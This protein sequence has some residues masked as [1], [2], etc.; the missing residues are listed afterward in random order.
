[1]KKTTKRIIAAMT[2]AATLTLVT[3]IAAVQAAEILP[4]TVP[5][6]ATAPELDHGY[7]V[8]TMTVG[9][10]GDVITSEDGGT[11]L[12]KSDAYILA[13]DGSALDYEDIKAGDVIT[14]LV[15]PRV[16][17]TLQ[18]PV[19]YSPAV[20]VVG[21]DKAEVTCK[22]AVFDEDGLSDDGEL[23]LNYDLTTPYYSRTREATLIS[24]KALVLYNMMTMSIPAQ[25][26]P[27][28]IVKL[29]DDEKLVVVPG[30]VAAPTEDHGYMAGTMT[31][32][33]NGETIANEDGS[34]H[35]NKPEEVVILT[36]DGKPANYE[37]IKT[38]DVIT[39]YVDGNAPMTLQLPVHYTPAVIVVGADEAEVTCKIAVFDEE[40]LSDDGELVINYDLTTPYY[41]R[42]REATFIS[43]KAL[44]L[45]N[46]MTMSIPAQ[47]NPLAIV[48][49]IDDEPEA[50][51][52]APDL[53]GVKNIVIGENTIAHLPVTVNG[54]QMLPVRAVAEALGYQVDWT[55]ET[56]SV[57]VGFASFSIDEDSYAFARRAP[58]SLG[59]APV[60]IALPTEK[61]ARTYVPVTFFTEVLEH[62]MTV[63]GDT[64][65]I[66]GN[67]EPMFIP[68]IAPG[69]V[70]VPVDVPTTLPLLPG[71]FEV[72][73]N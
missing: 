44:V 56:L 19:T 38:G 60:L 43:G 13:A 55:G 42:T 28:A 50:A 51:P 72:P 66:S 65:Y 24:G 71:E 57:N 31:V 20:I 58:Q 61:Y 46:M 49:L 25:T 67:D 37:D 27:L 69:E 11:C 9:E 10:N 30:P 7:L 54:V 22:I 35:L 15:D 68:P 36:A 41:S 39:Y 2:A 21:A 3:G 59:Q 4:I 26:N 45:Y 18:L 5:A 29:V 6:Q 40:G 53:T 48:K 64:L 73:M 63:E 16:P 14:Y 12:K 1:M 34:L 17:Q 32:G 8:G 52:Q 23:K 70:Q 47:T 33:E 62:R